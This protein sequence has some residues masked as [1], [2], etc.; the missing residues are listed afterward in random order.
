MGWTTPRTWTTSELVTAS[1]MNTHLRDQ[2]NYLYSGKEAFY[3]PAKAWTPA[4]TNGCGDVEVLQHTAQRPETIALPFDKDSDEHA[5][6]SLMMPRKWNLSTITFQV[7]WSCA[8]ANTSTVE[9]ALAGV[10]VADGESLDVAQGAFV[11]V[12]DTAL[13]LADSLHKT[14]ESGS[15][16][17]AGT[18]ADGDLI[19][20]DIMRD[21]S[22]D[23]LAEDAYL[24][25]VM[26]FYTSDQH[27]EA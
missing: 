16:T 3:L 21:V 4:S 15:V 7:H 1:I 5:I 12:N 11:G 19:T 13:N 26:I 14:A 22:A 20:L 2:L 17:I 18:P 23:T 25:G 27:F 9:W 24:L 6:I 8:S 10:A